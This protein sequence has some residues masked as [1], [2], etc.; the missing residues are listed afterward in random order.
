M[1]LFS[2]LYNCYFQVMQSVLSKHSFA[3]QE[4]LTKLIDEIGYEE[5]S[6]YLLPKLLSGEWNF[7][8]K[9]DKG[10][11]SKLKNVNELPL[12]HLQRSFIKALLQ[13][14]KI[15]LFF[16]EEEMKQWSTLWPGVEP[17]WLL[18]DF[19]Y[20]DQFADGDAYDSPS[21]QLHFHKVL[22]A[23]RESRY[24]RIECVSCG[25][26]VNEMDMAGVQDAAGMHDVTEGQNT[27]EGQDVTGGHN[28][29][30]GQD[31]AQVQGKHTIHTVLPCSLE[32]SVRNDQFRI[33]TLR[34]SRKKEKATV[35]IIN[36][37]RIVSIQETGRYASSPPSINECLKRLYAKE[38]VCIHIRNERNALERAMLQF[39]N[40]EKDTKHIEGNLYECRIYY[41]QAVENELLIELLTFGPMLQVVGPDRFVRRI[42]ERLRWQKM[43]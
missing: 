34:S 25:D 28:A 33:L 27:A 19:H 35:H 21:Y 12:S 43:L 5:T 2:E 36:M 7:F 20:I 16:T 6:Y 37:G 14:P 24:L 18:D 41:N 22:L 11:H 26:E 4:E 17:L 42:K 3:N 8:T 39:A 1:N 13:D 9:N 15:Q 38:P 30:E 31:A 10:I 23:I 32:Y 40:Y 29:S